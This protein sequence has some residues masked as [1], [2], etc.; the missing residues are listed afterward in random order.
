M[1]NNVCQV[2][3]IPKLCLSL[4]F[5]IGV[6]KSVHRKL[7]RLTR[8]LVALIANNPGALLFC[9]R[10]HDLLPGVV[11]RRCKVCRVTHVMGLRLNW[12]NGREGHYSSGPTALLTLLPLAHLD[13][14]NPR[15]VDS[16]TGSGERNPVEGLLRRLDAVMTH[17]VLCRE[18][19]RLT[20]VFRDRQ[21]RRLRLSGEQGVDADKHAGQRA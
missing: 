4:P 10:Y 17:D 14:G 11:V 13:S 7:K 16:D 9:N 8:I 6:S 19:E 5:C 21:F 3:A 2:F 20:F 18:R 1:E 15:A 12:R